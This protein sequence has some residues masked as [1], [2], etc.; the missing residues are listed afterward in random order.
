M[1][2]QDPQI[3]FRPTTNQIRYTARETIE[4]CRAERMNDNEIVKLAAGTYGRD[5]FEFAVFV[6]VMAGMKEK[7]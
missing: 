5:S 1:T 2:T 3:N 7:I 6:E 4:Q